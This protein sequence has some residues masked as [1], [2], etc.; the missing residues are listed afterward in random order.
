MNLLE[1]SLELQTNPNALSIR[2]HG[3]GGRVREINLCSDGSGTLGWTYSSGHFKPLEVSLSFLQRDDFWVNY[4]STA[5]KPKG[6]RSAR[7]LTKDKIK[8][9]VSTLLDE[10]ARR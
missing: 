7:E 4:R 6:R 9:L 5:P 3:T 8:H 1:A 2:F 10:L